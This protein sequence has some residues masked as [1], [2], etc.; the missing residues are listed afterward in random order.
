M[1][2]VMIVS[3]IA[4]KYNMFR[5]KIHGYADGILLRESNIAQSSIHGRWLLRRTT[6]GVYRTR[7]IARSEMLVQGKILGLLVTTNSASVFL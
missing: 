7:S 3:I 6:R 5:M 2:W 1:L 4:K